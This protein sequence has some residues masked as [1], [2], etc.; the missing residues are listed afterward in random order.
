MYYCSIININGS[1]LRIT[2]KL[3]KDSCAPDKDCQCNNYL[4]N[5]FRLGKI[6]D[7]NKTKK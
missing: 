1:E 6:P 2:W 7:K 3:S 4:I 5:N